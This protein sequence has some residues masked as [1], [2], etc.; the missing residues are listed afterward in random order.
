MRVMRD[1][2]RGALAEVPSRSVRFPWVK[3]A[4]ERPVAEMSG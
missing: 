4:R 3:M 1:A 2:K